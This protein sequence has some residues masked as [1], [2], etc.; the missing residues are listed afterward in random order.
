MVGL[1]PTSLPTY[2]TLA[3]RLLVSYG[4]DYDRPLAHDFFYQD[5][6]HA[7]MALLCIDDALQMDASVRADALRRAQRHFGE[8]RTCASEA[9]LTDETCSLLGVQV[10]IQAEL[11]IADTTGRPP[12]QVQGMS[13]FDTILTCL[14]HPKLE[15]RAEKLKHDFHV[16]EARYYALRVRAYIATQDFHSLWRHVTSRRPP[17]GYVTIVQA[18]VHAGHVDEA[19]RYMN[20]GVTMDKANRAKLMYVCENGGQK[21]GGN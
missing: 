7:D 5:D 18:L 17:H 21:H 1:R 10:A 8:D 4:R 11:N 14:K 16:P 6:R 20:R 2:T 3:P 19:S 12:S 9:R 15:K 13:L